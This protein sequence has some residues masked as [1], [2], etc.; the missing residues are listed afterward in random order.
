MYCVKW[1]ANVC[2][3]DQQSRLTIVFN[4]QNT[5]EKCLALEPPK[6]SARANDTEFDNRNRNVSPKF[7][8]NINVYGNLEDMLILFAKQFCFNQFY[9]IIFYLQYISVNELVLFYVL[10]IFVFFFALRIIIRFS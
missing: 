4:A 2:G 6:A 8:L 7:A 9:W 10:F 3:A 5:Y 1:Y